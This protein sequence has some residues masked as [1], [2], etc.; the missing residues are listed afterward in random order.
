MVYT[1]SNLEFLV[2]EEL[3]NDVRENSNQ[4]GNQRGNIE[5]ARKSSNCHENNAYNTFD[6]VNV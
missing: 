4:K 5:T 2:E 1:G 6:L 3:T